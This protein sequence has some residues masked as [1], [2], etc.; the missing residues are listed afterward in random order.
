MFHWPKWTSGFLT[1]IFQ[2]TAFKSS[3]C[4]FSPVTTRDGSTSHV[5][6]IESRANDITSGT[7]H[8]ATTNTINNVHSNTLTV[9]LYN[10]ETGDLQLCDKL[11]NVLVT[12]FQA[13]ECNFYKPCRKTWECK[14]NRICEYRCPCPG[15]GEC[16]LNIL[17]SFMKWNICVIR[18]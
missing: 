13:T 15:N 4:K 12:P 7:T 18:V 14:E 10:G 3:Q 1:Y 17:D 6:T 2:F 11:A 5:L 9:H 8:P 16:Q